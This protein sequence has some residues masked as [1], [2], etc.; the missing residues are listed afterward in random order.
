MIE[1]EIYYYNDIAEYGRGY[2]QKFEPGISHAYIKTV[3]VRDLNDAWHKMQGEKWALD[4]EAQP[5]I[6]AAGVHHTS[7]SI[8]DVALGPDGIV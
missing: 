1:F 4:G 6:E 3:S 7:M 5:I 2:N 8:G